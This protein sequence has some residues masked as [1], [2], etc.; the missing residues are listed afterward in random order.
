MLKI[1]MFR[2]KK[3]KMATCLSA[4][5]Q[6]ILCNVHLCCSEFNVDIILNCCHISLPVPLPYFA[7]IRIALW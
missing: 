1:E 5:G 6:L 2:L 7:P 4:P 3:F